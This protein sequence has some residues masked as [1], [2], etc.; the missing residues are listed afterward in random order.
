MCVNSA[1][2]KRPRCSLLLLVAIQCILSAEEDSGPGKQGHMEIQK[3]Q[4]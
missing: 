2:E 3:K 1:I 4:K